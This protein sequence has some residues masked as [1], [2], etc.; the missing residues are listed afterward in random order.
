MR[1][2]FAVLLIS[3]LAAPGAMAQVRATPETF[4]GIYRNEHANG[5][6]ETVT[7]SDRSGLIRG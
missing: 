2:S 7:I 5:R 3:M 1:R 6:P 4:T